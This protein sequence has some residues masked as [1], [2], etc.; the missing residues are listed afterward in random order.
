MRVDAGREN[1]FGRLAIAE[2]DRARLVEQQR[3][4]VA[5]GFDGAAARGED[6]ALQDAVHAGDTDRRK[7]SADGRRDEADQQRD[8]HDDVRYAAGIFD[9][10]RERGYRDEKDDRQA[11][12]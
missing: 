3:V 8:E 9:E 4:D 1:D 11:R 5:R 7:Q 6:V 12:E 10:R 2:R